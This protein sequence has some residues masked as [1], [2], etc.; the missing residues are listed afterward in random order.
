MDDEQVW[1]KKP[2]FT[3]GMHPMQHNVSD[4]ITRLL[5][6]DRAA[7]S[8][9]ISYLESQ[10]QDHREFALEVMQGLSTNAPDTTCHRLGFTGSPGVG[11]STLINAF[12]Q[13]FLANNPQGQLAILTIDPSSHRHGGSILG[14]KSRMPDIASDPRVFI[15]P[16]PSSGALGGVNRNTALVMQLL[17]LVGYKELWIESVGVGQS[18]VSIADLVDTLLYLT[19]AEAGDGLQGI[20]RGV[21][22][23]SDIVVFTKIDDHDDSLTREVMRQWKQAMSLHQHE[24]AG[25]DIPLVK[26]SAN[27]R[28]GFDRLNSAVAQF[29]QHQSQGGFKESRRNRQRKARIRGLAEA[30]LLR[31]F[32]EHPAVAKSIEAISLS[33]LSEEAMHKEVLALIQ[34]FRG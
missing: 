9:T 33:A 16:S 31:Q 8:K 1:F 28:L 30:A 2:T 15:R 12:A 19:Q 24:S 10:R 29:I 27:N 21:V 25:W 34:Q 13:D 5:E 17:Y 18:E 4:W 6:G 32:W 23:T 20:K 11:K 14:D 26:T 22:E 3:K 7:L